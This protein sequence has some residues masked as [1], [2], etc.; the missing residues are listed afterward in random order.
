MRHTA[1]AVYRAALSVGRLLVVLALLL[2]AALLLPALAQAQA[3]QP[4]AVPTPADNFALRDVGFTP[5]LD[6]QVPL[7]L[8]FR[9][10]TG[11]AVRLADYI[12]DRPVLVSLND[13]TCQDLCPLELQNLVDTMDQVP[14]RLGSEYG[15][16]AISINPAN[17]AADATSMRSEILHRYARPDAPNAADGWHFLTGDQAAI[18][19]LTQIVGFHYAYDSLAKDYAHPVGVVLL[20]PDGRVA[21]Y[22]YGM[23]F[24]ANDVR[25]ALTEAS[26]RKISTPVEAVLLL[27]YHYDVGRGRYTNI[28][29]GAVRAGGV[30]T[31][32]GMGA[33]LGTMLLREFR[34]RAAIRPPADGVASGVHPG[35]ANAQDP[36]QPASSRAPDLP[37]QPGSGEAVE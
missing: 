31:L 36:A 16:L 18:T 9:D 7:D 3:A 32:L 1:L 35:R 11:K 17:T 6:A 5:H 4:G 24:P 28:A 20:T 13:F 14:F 26:Q 37:A 22:L 25:L 12:H 19:Q 2:A 15:A 30:L 33:L 23:D 10:E 34:G 8:S 27:C 29:L 21:R